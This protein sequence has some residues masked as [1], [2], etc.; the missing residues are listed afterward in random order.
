MNS[1]SWLIYLAGAVGN[2]GIL[3][4][5]IIAL[6]AIAT[7]VLTIAKLVMEFDSDI[8]SQ[9]ETRASFRRWA[10]FAGIVFL[11]SGIIE[12]VIP[13]RKTV[14]LIAASEIGE[15]VLNSDRMAQV[16][17]RVAGI[18]DPSLDLLN[19][20]IAQQT[21]SIRREM[22]QTAPSEKAR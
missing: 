5:W 6:S 12:C 19:T 7:I 20:W 15:R 4:G 3:F 17:N 10:I 16:E 18:V 1:L 22:A 2:F 14:L 11:F 21:Q 8:R 13:D 9:P